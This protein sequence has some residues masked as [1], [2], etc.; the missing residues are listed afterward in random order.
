MINLLRQSKHWDGFVGQTDDDG[1]K[2]TL[3]YW[4]HSTSTSTRQNKRD[5]LASKANHQSTMITGAAGALTLTCC[6]TSLNS[7]ITR[8]FT[9]SKH[10][11]RQ[12]KRLFKNNPARLRINRNNPT[13]SHIYD[14][15][16]VL[17]PLV[18]D[19][20]IL[21]TGW[22]PPPTEDVAVEAMK[23]PFSVSRTGGKPNGAVGFLPGKF[24]FTLRF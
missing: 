20:K 15:K 10:S 18:S 13:K 23:Y 6:R 17:S 24:I 3:H 22:V 7:Q 16:P 4:T 2:K 9:R 19:V 21:P 5:T 11:N 1:R 14:Q 12:V 8:V